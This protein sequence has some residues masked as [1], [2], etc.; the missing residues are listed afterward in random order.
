[1]KHLIPLAIACRAGRVLT[2]LVLCLTPPGLSAQTTGLDDIVIADGAGQ[3]LVQAHATGLKQRAGKAIGAE[4][5]ARI[6]GARAARQ[7]AW[8]AQV[9]LH[10]VARLDEDRKSRFDS[11]FCGGPLMVQQADGEWIQ[12]GIVSWNRAPIGSSQKCGHQSLYGV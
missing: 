2:G 4:S 8:P 10:M 7:G 5:A 6:F 1:M 11:Q 3:V 9:S 12:V